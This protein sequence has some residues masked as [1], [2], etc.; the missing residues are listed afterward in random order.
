[1]ACVYAKQNKKEQAVDSLKQSIYKGLKDPDLK[2]IRGT[3]Y[4]E[5]LINRHKG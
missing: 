3:E 2:N 5:F 4:Y 1:M